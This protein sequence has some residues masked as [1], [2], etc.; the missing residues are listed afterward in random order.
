MDEHKR[1]TELKEEL[2]SKI[3][4]YISA[5]ES[6]RGIYVT[7]LKYRKSKRMK[8]FIVNV[9]LELPMGEFNIDE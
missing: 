3:E 7:G 1:L 4:A 8:Q 9:S 6:E 5:W 2:K